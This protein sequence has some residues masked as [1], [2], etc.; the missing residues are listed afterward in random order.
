[1]SA[2]KLLKQMNEIP[3]RSHRPVIR[4]DY[5]CC[6]LWQFSSTEGH[7]P[8]SVILT[9]T[10]GGVPL[11]A[12]IFRTTDMVCFS[13]CLAL[14]YTRSVKRK[15]TAKH[16]GGPLPEYYVMSVQPRGFDGR[17]EELRSCNWRIARH[18]S[19]LQALRMV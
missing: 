16:R 2:C 14:S 18:Q 8:L 15:D 10:L 13:T 5:S 9:S 6:S 4:V 7:S 11:R 19:R 3:T 12:S 1:M 17:N